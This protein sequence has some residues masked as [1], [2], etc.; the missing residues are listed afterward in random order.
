MTRES[1]GPGRFV[2]SAIFLTAASYAAYADII[3]VQGIDSIAI[4]GVGTSIT[5]TGDVLTVG[6]Y[7]DPTCSANTCASAVITYSNADG[8]VSVTGSSISSVGI[9]TATASL[10]YFFKVVG[11]A[12]GVT[13]V[14]IIIPTVATT[15]GDASGANDYAIA[16]IF[17]TGNLAGEF[18]CLGATAGNAHCNSAPS[19]FSNN[20]ATNWVVGN[21][22]EVNISAT[23]QYLSGAGPITFSAS[24]DPM[25]EIDPTFQYASDF[26]LQFS[27]N[28]GSSPVPEPSSLWL[29]ATC[30][31][32]LAG[33]TLWR[34]RLAAR[35]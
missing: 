27:P 23:F 25:P 13:S 20:F 28:L 10:D 3:P 32:S 35:P 11:S 30:L 19:S 31:L 34:K 16:G 15:S 7:S 9:V 2:L 29:L 33:A 22:S 6:T 18:A 21:T 14:P 17:A 12:P 8:T 26:A 5:N 4:A 24:V 1:A